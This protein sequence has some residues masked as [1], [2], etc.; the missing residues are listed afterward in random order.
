MTRPAAA[1][2]PAAV[3]G[4]AASAL[5]RAITGERTDRLPVWFMRQAGRSLPEYRE[6]RVGTRM[7]D[8]CLT[9]ELAAEITLQPVR[10]HGVDAGIFFSDIVVPLKLAGVD[11]EIEPGRGPVF[12][13]PVR[14]AADVDRLTAIEPAAV[15]AAAT[16]VAEAVRIVTTELGDTPLI[17]FAGAP[18]TLAAYLVEGGP[19]KEHLRARAMMHADPT[20]W[21]RLAGWLAEVSAAFLGV[22]IAAGASAV[23]LFDSWAGSLS[24]SDYTTFI[25]PHSRRALEGAGVPRI[26]FGVGTGHLLADMRLGGIADTVGV[27]WRT[28]LDEAVEVLGT[29]VSVQGNIDPAL[30]QAPWEVVEAHVREVVAR[31]RAARA[32]VLNL[33][34]GVPPET[35]PTVLT[36]IVELAHEIGG[37]E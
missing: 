3:A 14:T 30:L 12:A 15:A 18:F 25:A 21:H 24:R 19:S 34:H 31:G 5:V 27:D 20:S 8:A 13:S 17:G 10:R 37:I 36:R 32:H 7:L 23:Q 6:L 1:T 11:V 16:P 28:P 35:D 2:D 26:H 9:P 33:G 4:P 22:Q 29:D